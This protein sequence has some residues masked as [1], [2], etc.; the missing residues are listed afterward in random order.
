MMVGDTVA[1]RLD[2]EYPSERRIVISEGTTSRTLRIIHRNYVTVPRCRAGKVPRRDHDASGRLDTLRACRATSQR[3][4]IRHASAMNASGLAQKT[5]ALR[6]CQYRAPRCDV[7]DRKAHVE[8]ASSPHRVE[9]YD[10]FLK[11][12]P[13]EQSSA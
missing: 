7:R 3:L 11:L 13:A 5:I 4:T 9:P 10:W 12:A 2:H 6:Q 8:R 1:H